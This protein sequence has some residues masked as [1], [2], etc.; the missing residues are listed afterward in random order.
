MPEVVHAHLEELLLS[1]L[2]GTGKSKVSPPCNEL[3]DRFKPSNEELGCG[4]KTSVHEESA[5][6]F[7]LMEWR[8]RIGANNKQSKNENKVLTLLRKDFPLG[9]GRSRE[10]RRYNAFF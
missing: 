8:H 5:R 7:L 1:K 9:V 3:R 10:P 6:T 2:L 4:S